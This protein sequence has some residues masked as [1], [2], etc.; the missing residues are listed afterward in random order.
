[1]S[2]LSLSS[3]GIIVKTNVQSIILGFSPLI[4][5]VVVSVAIPSFAM[6]QMRDQG[7]SMQQLHGNLKL[8]EHGAS[9]ARGD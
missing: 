9:E 5:A 2:L 6:Q 8:T 1:M 7:E 3:K 4:I